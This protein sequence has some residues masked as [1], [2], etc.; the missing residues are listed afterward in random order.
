MVQMRF[1]TVQTHNIGR[2]TGFLPCA[3]LHAF[4][5]TQAKTVSARGVQYG[6][7]PFLPLTDVVIAGSYVETPRWMIFSPEA[8]DAGIEEIDVDDNLS[9]VERKYMRNIWGFE[10]DPAK[11]DDQGK[12][13]ILSGIFGSRA[14]E[15]GV[16]FIGQ[17]EAF[18][19]KQLAPLIQSV[20]DFNLNN[21]EIHF[22]V[23]GIVQKCGTRGALRKLFNMVRLSPEANI[24]VNN[25]NTPD[26]VKVTITGDYF[27]ASLLQGI[28]SPDLYSNGTLFAPRI[29]IGIDI[30][31]INRPHNLVITAVTKK[32]TEVPV[33]AHMYTINVN[34][35]S[36]MVL[37]QPGKNEAIEVP[38]N[39]RDAADELKRMANEFISEVN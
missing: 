34:D 22:L 11:L 4:F 18:R 28:L 17:Y 23:S 10:A 13:D 35:V 39:S 9:K 8:I 15:T 21:L 38:Q 31:W 32:S 2:S 5:T 1:K 27:T 3:Q 16:L 26:K 25:D 19:Q 24:T 6:P 37:G 36:E 30:G 7:D 29:F 20:Q 33:G 12:M 14:A